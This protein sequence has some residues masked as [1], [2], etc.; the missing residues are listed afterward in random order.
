MESFKWLIGTWKTQS[1]DGIIME[2]W[3][4]MSDTSFDGETS[5]YK[6]T[7]ETVTLEKIRLVA[8][9]KNYYYIPVVQGQNNNR[10]VEF[11][12]TAYSKKGFVAEN[13]QQDFPKRISYTIKKDSLIAFIEDGGKRED[14]N[15]VR[16]KEK[17]LKR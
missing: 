8:R 3:R 12:I 10:A 5:L 15:Y 16:V 2:T 1:K 7:T 14:Y 11:R 6:K 17:A 4:P 9:G 13:P